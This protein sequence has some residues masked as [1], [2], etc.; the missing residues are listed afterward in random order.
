MH[1]VD[2]GLG[3]SSEHG[4]TVKKGKKQFSN[5]FKILPEQMQTDFNN[6]LLRRRLVIPLSTNFGA[7][8][9]CKKYLATKKLISVTSAISFLKIFSVVIY[10]Y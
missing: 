5:F 4:F 6:P 9:L 7:S 3:S 1:F 10:L 8:K 2:K